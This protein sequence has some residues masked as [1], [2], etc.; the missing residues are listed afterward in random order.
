MQRAVDIWLRFALVIAGIALPAT[1]SAANFVYTLS[2]A[3]LY[4]EAE[5]V[6]ALH[7]DNVEPQFVAGRHCGTRFDAH[8]L[9]VFKA[10]SPQKSLVQIQFGDRRG[11][12]L[13]AGR[14]YFVT[15]KHIEDPETLYGKTRGGGTGWSQM[16][17][18]RHLPEGLSREE[19]LAFLRCNGLNAA[20]HSEVAWTIADRSI[21]V[22]TPL[23]S[24]WPASIP[25]RPDPS[26]PSQWIVSK[27]ELLAYFRSLRR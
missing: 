15:L 22:T 23:P 16:A 20:L 10:A 6:A 7:I 26:V 5:I 12:S 8:V 18:L 19:A 25:K 3:E 4:D 17:D 1:R 24:E 2:L 13:A 14:D 21:V 27:P 11:D 9:S